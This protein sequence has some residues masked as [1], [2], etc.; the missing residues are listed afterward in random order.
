[1]NALK[2]C[3]FVRPHSRADRRV[4]DQLRRQV[5]YKLWRAV[6]VSTWLINGSRVLGGCY[7]RVE[8]RSKFGGN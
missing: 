5:D 8:F 7:A 1:M 6:W 4:S 2:D 3:Q